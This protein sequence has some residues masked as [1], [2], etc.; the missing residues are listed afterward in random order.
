[1]THQAEKEA[2]RRQAIER[3]FVHTRP[4]IANLPVLRAILDAVA[5][6]TGAALEAV[7][8]RETVV[9]LLDVSEGTLGEAHARADELLKIDFHVQP[10]RAG[11]VIG[12]APKLVFR[13]LDAMFG[14]D[15]SAAAPALARALTQIEDQVARRIAHIVLHETRAGLADVARMSTSLEALHWAE[16]VDDLEGAGDPV[17]ILELAVEE[18]DESILVTLPLP[19]L[20][21]ARARL[22]SREVAAPPAVDASFSRGFERNVLATSAEIIATARGPAMTLRDV[23]ALEV[24]TI[25]EVEAAAFQHVRLECAGAPVFEGRLGQSKGYFTICVESAVARNVSPDNA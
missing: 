15:G 11:G 6:R 12:I 18:H 4:P 25:V 9:T 23:A 1:M 3:M 19:M 5:V 10:W 13:V 16:P 2:T 24:G 8:A 17:L 14:G 20:E 7:L 21:D 22:R